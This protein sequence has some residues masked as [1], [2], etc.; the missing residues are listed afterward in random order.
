MTEKQGGS[1]VRANTT[2]ARPAERRRARRRVRDHR[3]QVVLLGADVRRLP[4]PRPDRRRHLLLPDA[5]LDARRRAQPLPHPAPQGQ[6]RQPLQRLQRGRVPTAPGR[7]MVGEEGRGV[8]TI[9]EMVNHTRLDC[10]LG[11]ATGDA[12]RSRAGDPPRRPPLR[13]RQDA[14]RSAADAERARRP[15]GRVRGGDDLGAAAR[16][17]LRRGD[18]RRRGGA[19]V[20]AP[21]QRR[22]QVLDL[23]ARAL[24]TRSRRSSASAAT[25]TSRSRGCRASTARAR[26]PRSGRAR[27]TS[28]ASTS[29]GR[30][31]RARPRSRPSSPRSTRRAGADPRLD[32]FAAA[33]REELPATSTTIEPRARRLVERMALALQG[34]LLVRYGDEAVADAFCASRLDGDWGQRLR[35]PAGRTDFGRIIERHRPRA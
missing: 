19:R 22:P 9:I 14:G 29:C 32:R 11:G 6:A 35:H 33:L 16:P 20:Q 34:S 12:G 7:G 24:R 25:A 28:S 15:R 3:P 30:W 27:A 5:A 8:P 13:L 26:S 18:R 10:V 23:Q 17:R 4:R 21:R 2:V 31:S 1:D